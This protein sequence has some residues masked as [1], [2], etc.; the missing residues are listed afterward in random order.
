MHVTRARAR[1]FTM[2][3][4]VITLGVFAIVMAKG[5]PAIADFNANSRLRSAAADLHQGATLAR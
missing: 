4:M 3:E 1:G 5:L 2:V